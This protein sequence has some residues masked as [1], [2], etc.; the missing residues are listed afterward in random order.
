[1]KLSEASETDDLLPSLYTDAAA[2]VDVGSALS[3]LYSRPSVYTMNGWLCIHS[4][5]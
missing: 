1:M 4:Q 5:I 2:A 3:F